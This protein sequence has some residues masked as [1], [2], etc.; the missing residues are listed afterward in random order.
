MTGGTLRKANN[1]CTWKE[2]QEACVDAGLNLSSNA[3]EIVV[4]TAYA[5][6]PAPAPNFLLIDHQ[7]RCPRVSLDHSPVFPP[8]V[9]APAVSAF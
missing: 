3:D 5:P 6:A 1:S 4:D 8:L 7:K 9:L 2:V